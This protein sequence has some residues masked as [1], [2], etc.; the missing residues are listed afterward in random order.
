MHQTMMLTVHMDGMPTKLP[1]YALRSTVGTFLQPIY[2][3]PISHHF[4]SHLSNSDV[5][6]KM[7]VRFKLVRSG[8]DG[9]YRDLKFESTLMLASS[10]VYQRETY[11]K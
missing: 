6:Y 5:S 9:I 8:R 11:C 4:T 2:A 10:N 1:H 7:Y 3:S